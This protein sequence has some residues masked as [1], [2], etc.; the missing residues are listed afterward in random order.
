LFL[1]HFGPG[2]IVALKQSAVVLIFKSRKKMTFI[3]SFSY[4]G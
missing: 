2:C 3:I 4:F 1:E